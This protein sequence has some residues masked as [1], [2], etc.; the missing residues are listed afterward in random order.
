MTTPSSR[1]VAIGLRLYRALAG[2]FPQEFQNAYGDEMLQVAE[3]SIEPIWRRHGVIGLVRLLVDIIVR[4]PIEYWTEMRQDIRYG[5][6]KLAGS[7]GFTAAALISLSLGICAPTGF[8]SEINGTVLRD[9]PGAAHPDQLVS[10]NAPASYPTYRRVQERNDLF[11]STLAYVAPV[12]FGVSLGGRKERIWGH[13]VTPSYFSALGVRPALGRFFDETYDQ[14]GLTPAVVVSH[15]MWQNDLSSDPEVIGKPLRINGHP[16]TILGIGP[17]DFLGASPMFFEADLWLPLSAGGSLAPELSDNA[18]ERRDLRM[19]QVVGRLRHGITVGRAEAELDAIAGRGQKGGR[20]LLKAGGKVVPVRKRDLPL[21]LALPTVVVG[22][23]LLIACSNVANMMLARATG[24]R[25][26]IAVRLAMGASRARLVRQ[27]L[28]E[29]MLVATGAGIIGL[30]LTGWLMSMISRMEF[31]HAMPVRFQVEPDWRVLLFTLALTVCTGLVFGM[32]PALQA[33]KMDL[34]R[35]LKEGGNVHI[36]RYRPLSL[37]NMMVLYQMA[38]SLALVLVTGTVVVA[39]LSITGTEAGFDPSGL[40]LISVDPIRDG[41]SSEQTAA[42]LHQILDRMKGLPSISAASLTE[43]LP[44]AATGHVTF[45]A[46]GVPPGPAAITPRAINSATK[47]VV[48]ADYFATLGIPILLGRGFRKEDE[49]NDST[50]VIVSEKLV[51][52]YWN[53]ENV[54]GRHIEI[55]STDGARF[56]LTAGSSL[57]YR[58]PARRQHRSLEVIGVA[59]DVTME[60]AMGRARPAIYF[61]LNPEVCARPSFQGLT[62]LVR[63]SPSLDAIGMVRRQLSSIDARLT[64]F[65]VRTMPDEIDRLRLPVRAGA[66]GYGLMGFFGVILA[67]AGVA[68]VTA[69]AVTQ[70]RHEIGIRIALGAQSAQVLALVMKEG[71]TLVIAGTCIGLAGAWALIRVLSASVEPVARVVGGATSQPLLLVGAP[72][73]LAGLAL[74]ACYIP[75]RKSTRIDPVRALRQ[76]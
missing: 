35:S 37:R 71:A 23:L 70:R 49:A 48:G 57:D 20:I 65:R 66:S 36:R 12:P 7:P 26:E 1:P 18:L 2:T 72:V 54:L 45:S 10:L 9:L 28:T 56:D 64:P 8:F 34:T 74:A 14:P 50:A 63:V 30:L 16:C 17:K 59:K 58:S 46:G 19:F 62:L 11:T 6:R 75:A 29:S 5:L 44:M 3:E 60:S 55:E 76:D 53:G 41:F 51:R 33:T 38:A 73:L 24:R 4:L 69:Y 32:A 52:E 39:F 31:A 61:P 42:L 21:V 68:G 22:L 47:Y 43:S 15:R 40:Y 25:Q 27:L 67:A 13:L